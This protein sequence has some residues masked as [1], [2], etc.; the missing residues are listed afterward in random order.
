MFSGLLE[1][2]NLNYTFFIQFLIFLSMYPVL[3]RLLLKPYLKIYSL[4]EKETKNRMRSAEEWKKKQEVLKQ[5][6]VKKAQQIHNK[7]QQI[8][9]EK[10]RQITEEFLQKKQT[11]HA[12]IQ[13]EF[14]H[15]LQKWNIELKQVKNQSLEQIKPLSEEIVNRLSS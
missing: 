3:S 12:E 14:D 13:K 6:Y 2:L 11:A 8:F 15:S 1:A 5:E 4:R 7:F 10:S 9:S